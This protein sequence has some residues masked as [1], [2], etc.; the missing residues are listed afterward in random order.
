MAV[1]WIKP[2]ILSEC[3]DESRVF[4]NDMIGLDS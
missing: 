1:R 4:Y 3:F 2:N